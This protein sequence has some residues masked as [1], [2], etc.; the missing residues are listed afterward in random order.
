MTDANPMPPILGHYR[1]AVTAAG[2]TLHVAGQV[3]VDERGEP[4]GV[5][6]AEA[7][8]ARV[9]SNLAAVIA[10]EGCVMADIVALRVYVTTPAAAKA[11]AHV[12]LD[13]FPANPPAS[14][15]LYVSGLAHQD[16]QLEVEAVAALPSPPA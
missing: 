16:W 14:T 13:A 11:W 8:A 5:G 2:P 10:A 7:Q 9:A 6:D 15:L 1:Q 12:R 4:V 3:P